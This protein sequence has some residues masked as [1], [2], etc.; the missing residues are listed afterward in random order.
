MLRWG[1]FEEWR[2]RKRG[3]TASIVAGNPRVIWDHPGSSG[4]GGDVCM[5]VYAHVCP[6]A[7]GRQARINITLNPRLAWSVYVCVCRGLGW[8]GDGCGSQAGRQAG[9]KKHLLWIP[10]L[11]S[12]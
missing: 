5:C 10:E 7:G 3:E 12:I 1:R 8:G 6:G 2:R 11:A 4:V 9:S